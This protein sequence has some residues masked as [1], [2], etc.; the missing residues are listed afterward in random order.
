M[1]RCYKIM[2]HILRVAMIALALA[3]SGCHQRVTNKNGKPPVEQENLPTDTLEEDTMSAF[4][5]RMQR[6]EALHG[7]AYQSELDK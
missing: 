1:N 7:G 4:I 5:E 3:A 2:R 6:W